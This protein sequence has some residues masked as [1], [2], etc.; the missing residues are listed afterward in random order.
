MGSLE[1]AVAAFERS[2][3]LEPNHIDNL[4]L[5]AQ[6][7]I[8]LGSDG[9]LAQASGY[10]R[11]VLERDKTNLEAIFLLGVVAYERGDYD[12]AVQAWE[13]SARLVDENDE[14]YAVIESALEDAKARSEGRVLTV[15]VQVSISEVLRNELPPGAHLFVF[16]RDPDGG[17]APIAVVRQRV[18]DFPMTVTLT[19][20]DAVMTDQGISAVK[21][22]LVGARLTQSGTIEMQVGD[23]EARPVLVEAEAGKRVE[24][25]ITEMRQ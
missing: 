6:T 24:L 20:A 19:D 25:R 5:Y 1:E 21:Q 2:R 3:R 22:W 12:R 14:R 7:L 9:E 11:Q 10:L 8:A 4:V 15:T 17:P 16:I 13:I 18:S 23:M